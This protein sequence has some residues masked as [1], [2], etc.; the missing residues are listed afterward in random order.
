M[1][2]SVILGMDRDSECIERVLWGYFRQSHRDFEILIADDGSAGDLE[3]QLARWRCDTGLSVASLCDESQPPHRAAAVNQA[4]QRAKGTY[5]VFS[6]AHCIPRWDFLQAHARLARRG[7]YIVGGNLTLPPDLSR[8]ITKEDVVSG[9]ATDFRW[10]N[11]GGLAESGAR[12]LQYDPHWARLWDFIAG[13]RVEWSSANASCWKA[14]LIE[15]NGLDE[16]VE[17]VA[18][19]Q[20]LGQRL[21]NGG[22][23][24]RQ[25]RHRAVC[26]QLHHPRLHLRRE[27]A[28]RG[29]EL[30]GQVQRS[31]ASWTSYGIHKGYR[32]IGVEPAPAT[33]DSRKS[34]RAVA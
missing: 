13:T 8:G 16:R 21:R 25:G 18:S 33:A 3:P 22:I 28:E 9:R 2:L 7:Q 30:F 32:V 5:L 10:L 4:I 12:I 19:D 27:V 17:Y 23:R 26:L 20:E 31:R 1:K 24:G 15:A 29:W 11:A 6:Y 34:R 14:D